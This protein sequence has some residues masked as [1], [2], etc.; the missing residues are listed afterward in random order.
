MFTILQNFAEPK[1]FL[2]LTVLRIYEKF[3]LRK[4]FIRLLKLLLKKMENENQFQ[5]NFGRPFLVVQFLYTLFCSFVL[6]FTKLLGK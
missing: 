4:L 6:N 5:A 1:F 3:V 2:C